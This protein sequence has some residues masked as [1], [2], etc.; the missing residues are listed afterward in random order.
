MDSFLRAIEICVIVKSRPK[1][2]LRKIEAS[3]LA[4]AIEGNRSDRTLKPGP[5][6]VQNPGI[7]LAFQRCGDSIPQMIGWNLLVYSG[8]WF[9]SAREVKTG[10]DQI[11][12]D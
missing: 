2:L 7:Y 1:V 12:Y 6:F 9:S 10:G 8:E 4:L 11:H 5:T 3:E